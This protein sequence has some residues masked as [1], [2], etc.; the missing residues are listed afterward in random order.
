MFFEIRLPFGNF[1]LL[2]I[3]DV[4]FY[5]LFHFLGFNFKIKKYL[6]KSSYEKALV[7]WYEHYTGEALKL[8]HPQTL[9]EKIQWLKLYNSTELKMQLSDKYLSRNYI[10]EITNEDFLIPILGVWNNANEIDFSKLPNQYVLKCNHGCGYNIV[11]KNNQKSNKIKIKNTL[12]RW[13]KEDYSL[14]NGAELQFKNI[15]KK[16]IAEEYLED[17]RGDL[18]SYKV[19]CFNGEPKYILSDKRNS[20]NKKTRDIYDLN[21]E[22]QNFTIGYSNSGIITQPPANIDKMIDA[23]KKLSKNFYFARIDFYNIDHKLY[24]A[25]ITFSPAGGIQKFTPVEYN[26]QLGQ[27]LNI[28]TD[29]NI[30]NNNKIC[31]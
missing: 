22:L 30:N 21:W 7:A 13:L 6:N 16:I 31:I 3:K 10:S 5:N 23:A 2:S 29:N 1:K 24:I 20:N 11:V 12:N 28:P 19:L 9:N 27:M 17:S 18:D 8:K 15:E 25:Q 26:L 14:K 4:G